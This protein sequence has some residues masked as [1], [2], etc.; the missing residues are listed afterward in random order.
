MQQQPEL[1]LIV[2]GI[3]GPL[4]EIQ[5]LQNN[6]ALNKWISVLAKAERQPSSANT[7]EL[8]ASVFNLQPA[9]DFPSA[10]LNLLG[11]KRYDPSKHYMHADPVHLRAD[12]DHA[13]LTSSKDLNISDSDA[14]ALRAALNQHFSQD[15]FNFIALDN[16]QW[17]VVSDNE[18]DMQ[19]TPLVEA[20]ARNINFL[21]PEGKHAGTW[22]QVLTEAQ[23][24]MHTHEV[25]EAR[26]QAGQPSINSLWFH[27]SGQLNAGL[28]KHRDEKNT[29]AICSNDKMLMGLAE[30]LQCDNLLLP[31]SATQY[32]ELLLAEKNRPFNVLYLSELEHLVNYT[33]V[34]LWLAAQQK[35]LEQ[36]IYPLLKVAKKNNIKLTLYP[37]NKTQYQF[38]KYDNLR[39]WRYMSGYAGR[40]E[41]L[42]NYVNSY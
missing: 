25:N 4:A 38:S 40:K 31:D 33:D 21:L 22:K 8:I 36:W 34:S 13:V 23:M 9:G 18:I 5:S 41:K 26:E 16:E 32:S 3:C 39:F 20:V 17:F 27:G 24:L 37:C 30:F 7:A 11:D 6:A 15:G 28:L 2:P 35:L 14:D 10:A 29:A 12:M 42:E 19:T 1:H